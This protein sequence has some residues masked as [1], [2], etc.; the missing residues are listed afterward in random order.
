MS[1][2][3]AEA[4]AVKDPQDLRQFAA[5]AQHLTGLSVDHILALHILEMGLF[6]DAPGGV[7]GVSSENGK[8]RDVLVHTDGIIPCLAGSGGVI[9]CVFS[10]IFPFLVSPE[11]R[12]GGW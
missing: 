5:P 9:R 4:V 10:A 11:T 7:F 8:D 3:D 1:L 6:L 2:N 12:K